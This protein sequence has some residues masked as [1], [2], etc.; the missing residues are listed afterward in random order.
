MGQGVIAI[1]WVVIYIEFV[2]R[3]LPDYQWDIHDACRDFLVGLQDNTAINDTIVE[4]NGTSNATSAVASNASAAASNAT[5][6]K[7]FF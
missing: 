1:V 2:Q 6:N 7:S 4:L 5:K 3:V